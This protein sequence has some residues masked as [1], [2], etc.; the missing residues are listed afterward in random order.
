MRYFQIETS[1]DSVWYIK[2]LNDGTITLTIEVFIDHCL[3][4]DSISDYLRTL[5][6]E[7]TIN[8]VSLT[9]KNWYRII[10]NLLMSHYD[11]IL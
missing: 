6:K 9:R 4:R 5:I 11:T 2:T 8:K 10:R 3:I 7:R 1:S